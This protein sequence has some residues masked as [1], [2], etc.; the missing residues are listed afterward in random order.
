MADLNNNNGWT[1]GQYSSYRFLFGCYIASLFFSPIF[2]NHFADSVFIDPELSH[3]P[4]SIN[5]FLW[6]Y[7]SIFQGTL[8]CIFTIFSLCFAIGLS[9][10]ICA[11]VVF[12]GLT[13]ISP[14]Y[15]PYEQLS[16][17]ALYII[18]LVHIFTPINPW[19]CYLSKDSKLDYKWSLSD[20]LHNCVWILCALIYLL[21]I[22][23]SFSLE[24]FLADPSISLV[25]NLLELSYLLSFWHKKP[26]IYTWVVALIITLIGFE[27]PMLFLVLLMFSP[28]WIPG[29]VVSKQEII[30][31]DGNCGLCHNWIKFI[32]SEDTRES[33]FS[34]SP[35]FSER[36][37]KLN[38]D[39]SKIE[40]SILIS[41]SSSN[42]LTKSR[43]VIYILS[44]LGGF[45][46]ALSWLLNLIPS[47]ILDI[48]YDFTAK[49]RHHLFPKTESS[50][51]LVPEPF[52]SRFITT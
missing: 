7:S 3:L 36:F 12:F 19:G 20:K 40:D 28:N 22:F 31:Y 52:K 8:L 42:I 41:D 2:L 35:L 17:D 26:R 37:N 44:S 46:R 9:D 15:L 39:P 6:D 43:A 11:L 45:W 48:G 25:I 10:K 33:P 21:D 38:L 13:S 4:K 24:L 1:G 18:L 27:A 47:I 14:Y 29:K 34:F 5:P 32:L 30:F 51:P 49:I 50:C 16:I 23:S